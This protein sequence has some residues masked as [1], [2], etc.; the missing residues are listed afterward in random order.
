MGP[1][2]ASYGIS[3]GFSMSTLASKGWCGQIIESEGRFR[4]LHPGEIASAMGFGCGII[5]PL[6]PAFAYKVLGNCIIPVH[7]CLHLS[8]IAVAMFDA[9]DP[10][11]MPANPAAM[12]RVYQEQVLRS[13]C[14]RLCVGALIRS[15]LVSLTP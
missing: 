10:M 6:D 3:L 2:M 4:L 1:I 11:M 9:N 14:V 15:C 13:S 5:L 8:R 7:A 12:L